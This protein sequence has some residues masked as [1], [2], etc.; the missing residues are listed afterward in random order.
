ML[1]QLALDSTGDIDIDGGSFRV[2]DDFAQR[3]RIR[4]RFLR[5]EWFLGRSEGVPYMTDI[6]IRSPNLNHILGALREVIVNTD[7][8]RTLTELKIASFDRQARK[9]VVQ[10]RAN[11]VTSTVPVEI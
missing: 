2:A 11:G 1:T 6:L 9:L 4:L 8:F 5:G 7:G 3:V 10:F